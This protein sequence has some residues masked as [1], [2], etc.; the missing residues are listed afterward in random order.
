MAVSY[1]DVSSGMCPPL[2]EIECGAVAGGR[3]TPGHNP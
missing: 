2:G 3:G 1:V